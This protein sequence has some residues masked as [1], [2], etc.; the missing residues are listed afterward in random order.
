MRNIDDIVT[1]FV[2]GAIFGVIA[3]LAFVALVRIFLW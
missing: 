2:A 3:A 1:V